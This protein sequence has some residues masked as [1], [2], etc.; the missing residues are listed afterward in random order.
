MTY[1]RDAL[2]RCGLGP[3]R[4]VL[5][6]ATGTGLLARA[7]AAL[8]G[9]PRRI[10]GADISRG[11]LREA[12][13]TCANPLVQAH[14]EM[15]PFRSGAFDMVMMGYALRHVADLETL[16]AVCHRVLA[17]GGRLVILEITTP[18]SAALRIFARAYFRHIVPVVSRLVTGSP[19]AGVLMQYYWDTIEHCVP[20]GTI[21]DALGRAGF[22]NPTRHVEK[23][24]FSEYIADKSDG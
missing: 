4:R 9:D 6:L 24:I 11:M 14:A 16:F 7:G 15:L 5:D 2:A 3:G 8:T 18:A 10:V 12:Q 22:S 13:L 23:G 21:L 20:P 1:R 19:A 17:P